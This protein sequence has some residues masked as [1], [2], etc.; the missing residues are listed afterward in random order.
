MRQRLKR[1]DLLSIQELQPVLPKQQ[2]KDLASPL[3]LSQAFSLTG[4][5]LSADNDFTIKFMTKFIQN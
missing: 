2:I 5:R 1:E 3:E 4:K